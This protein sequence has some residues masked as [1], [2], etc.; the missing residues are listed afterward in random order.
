MRP[1]L[2]LL[3]SK[4]PQFPQRLL[5]THFP[6]FLPASSLFCAH[7]RSTPCPSCSEG[8]QLITLFEGRGPKVSTAGPKRLQG[9][10]PTGAS[11]TAAEQRIWLPTELKNPFFAWS[12]CSSC[13]VA[14]TAPFLTKDLWTRPRGWVTSSERAATALMEQG[15]WH[16]ASAFLP[17][18][19]LVED[20]SSEVANLNLVQRPG[21]AF[22]GF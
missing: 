1:P 15:G 2:S 14:H 20:T 12:M 16:P 13:P 3:L 21:P 9:T 22:A 19:S 18:A 10:G 4:Q 6:A 17:S 7:S 8:P 11:I 5:I